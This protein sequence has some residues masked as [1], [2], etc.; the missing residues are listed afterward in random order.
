[1][2]SLNKPDFKLKTL[3]W[4]SCFILLGCNGYQYVSS[5]YYVPVNTDSSKLN[6]NFSLNNY[7]L[8]YSFKNFSLFTT[9]Y[10][11]NNK[12]GI[13]LF[14]KE[15]SGDYFQSDKHSEFTL[16]A[17]HYKALNKWFSYELV[18]G[19]GLGSV[20]YSNCQ[21]FSSD[22]EFNLDSKKFNLYLQPNFSIKQDDFFDFSIFSKISYNRYFNIQSDWKFGDK[23]IFEDYDE[24][25]AY[26]KHTSLYFF[27]PGFQIRLGWRN[28]KGLCTYSYCTEI[29][30]ANIQHRTYTLHLSIFLRFG[31]NESIP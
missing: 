8:G 16:G 19:T 4:F 13:H 27:E 9:G 26:K 10:H 29:T 6:C 24:Y 2:I 17:T 7:Q 11:R 28:V 1:M 21:D 20:E 3:V 30:G 31:K 22:Y 12:N 15:N 5:P 14:G 18:A 23:G 25:F